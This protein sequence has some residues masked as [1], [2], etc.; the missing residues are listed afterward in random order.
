MVWQG[1]P[2][3]AMHSLLSRNPSTMT[4]STS[5]SAGREQS[6]AGASMTPGARLVS[7]QSVDITIVE[8]RITV[9]ED[10]GFLEHQYS[11]NRELAISKTAP[12]AWM[13]R[14]CVMRICITSM[15]LSHSLLAYAHAFVSRRPCRSSMPSIRRI[16]INNGCQRLNRCEQLCCVV[17][18]QRL[19]RRGIRLSLSYE[20][21]LLM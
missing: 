16:H 12:T 21:G 3:T 13:M 19:D 20:R 11:Y 7:A 8:P 15:L 4:T 2:V 17:V 10:Y 9:R 1:W 18:L 14:V 6:A 5:A